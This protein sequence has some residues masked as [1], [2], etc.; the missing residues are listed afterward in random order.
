MIKMKKFE[1]I[2][3]EWFR[4]EEID[5][6]L[7]EFVKNEVIKIIKEWQ[8]DK[9]KCKTKICLAGHCAQIY[10]FCNFFGINEGDTI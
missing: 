4:N 3:D 8:K 10:W 1:E 6:G 9:K 5:E 2:T 7:D